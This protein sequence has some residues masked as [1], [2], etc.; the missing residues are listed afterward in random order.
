MGRFA[1]WGH[2]L[3]DLVFG[4]YITPRKVIIR[5]PT[6]GIMHFTFQVLI[7]LYIVIYV[8]VIKKSYL[9]V[10]APTGT[11]V[12]TLREANYSSLASGTAQYAALGA[13]CTN[14]GAPPVVGWAHPCRFQRYTQ[15]VYPPTV[16][17]FLSIITRS[18]R[19]VLLKPPGCT[20]ASL[21]CP[22]RLN[23]TDTFFAAA[24][25]FA[26]VYIDHGV[27]SQGG[28]I[29]RTLATMNGELVDCDG[30]TV[31]SFS[32]R[33][34]TQSDL[35]FILEHTVTLQQLLEAAS[36]TSASCARW[37]LETM[38][39]ASLFQNH[40]LR[41]D[42]A[43]LV[44]AIDYDN[45]RGFNQGDVRFRMSVSRVPRAEYQTEYS[46]LPQDLD[47]PTL[48]EYSSHG[49]LLVVLQ[50]GRLGE[51]DVVTMFVQLTAALTL[52]ALSSVVVNFVATVLMKR[53]QLYTK[54][55]FIDSDELKVYFQK[56][57]TVFRTPDSFPPPRDDTEDP[58]IVAAFHRLQLPGGGGP[59]EESP[60]EFGYPKPQPVS[61]MEEG[62]APLK[63]PRAA[64]QD[65]LPSAGGKAPVGPALDGRAGRGAPR[66][67]AN[68]PRTPKPAVA[69][70]TP[71]VPEVSKGHSPR[72][73]I[74]VTAQG[75]APFFLPSR[76]H[77]NPD[78][79]V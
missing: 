38:S 27:R 9:S 35:Q 31:R 11:A 52:L 59:E 58:D 18:R 6:L 30:R 62:S 65:A 14:L 20:Q 16:G 19:D 7:V 61:P 15:L 78:V 2:Q 36:G 50:G 43:I 46:V 71:P 66:A 70:P 25:E 23:S 57:R 29:Q 21:D 32:A 75:A 24:V 54:C 76:C 41:Y 55:L 26:T 39:D 42:G 45:T 8:M 1:A 13:Y 4:C 34:G 37:T 44:V 40:S 69:K 67:K 74:A 63:P 33:N 53:R 79:M 5:S 22:H 17:P 73:V 51:F 49:V 64:V 28:A 68:L 72:P 77:E 12:M 47:Q 48:V 10:T 56:D 3:L 60:H